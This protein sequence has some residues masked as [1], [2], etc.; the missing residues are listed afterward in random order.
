VAILWSVIGILVSGAAGGVAGW[1][2][3]GLLGLSGVAGALLAAIVGM[4]VATGA[5]VALTVSLR[6]LGLVR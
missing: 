2:I 3:M 6:K 5:W 1:W 4:V